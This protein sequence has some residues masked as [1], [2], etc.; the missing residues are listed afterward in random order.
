MKFLADTKQTIISDQ[1]NRI[2]NKVASCINNSFGV[3]LVLMNNISD[4]NDTSIQ[5]SPKGRIQT[6]VVIEKQFRSAVV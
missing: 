6:K 1:G 3:H 4:A 5:Q 2:K